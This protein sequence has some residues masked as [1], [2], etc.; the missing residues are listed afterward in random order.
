MTKE[1]QSSIDLAVQELTLALNPKQIYLFGSYA[2]G[3]ASVGS[4]IDLLVV[5]E[6]GHGD[7]LSNTTK[8]YRATRMLPVAKDIIVDHESVFKKRS[9]WLSSIEREVVDTGKL[10]YGGF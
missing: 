9:K 7:K 1:I 8:A 3:T 4:D 2:K 6:D 10:V 5:V